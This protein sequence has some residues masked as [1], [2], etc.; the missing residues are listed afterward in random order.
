MLIVIPIGILACYFF[1]KEHTRR[2]T[3]KHYLDTGEC[4]FCKVRDDYKSYI[5]VINQ[6]YHD[7]L[8][9]YCISYSCD[10]NLS[11]DKNIFC[12]TY[13]EDTDELYKLA[14]DFRLNRHKWKIVNARNGKKSRKERQVQLK[15]E[16]LQAAKQGT[17]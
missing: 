8:L 10:C 1:L 15:K 16:Q 9:H 3:V 2:Q 4:P 14:V 5:S 11:S 17:D 13:P 6:S 7:S 12:Q